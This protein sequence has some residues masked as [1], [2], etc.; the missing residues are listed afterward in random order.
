[1]IK[2]NPEKLPGCYLHRT[3]VNDVARVEDRTFICTSREGRRR[4]HQ[5]L[6]GSQGMLRKAHKALSTASMKG[7]TMYVIP[8]SM[9]IVGSDF[10]KVWHRAHGLHLR[11]TQHAHHD[12]SRYKRTRSYSATALTTSRVSTPRLTSM[13]K[14]AT[15][16]HFPEDNTIWSIN[17]GYGGNVLLGKKCFALRIAS[18]LGRKE[19]WMAEHM[20][21]LGVEYPERRSQVCYSSIPVRLR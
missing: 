3:A 17:S 12:K 21:I 1:M 15:S 5:Q 14:T 13:K 11:C 9:G 10:A 8:Y 2:L 20:L 19:G 4:Q 6:D 18:Y 16:A 7:R